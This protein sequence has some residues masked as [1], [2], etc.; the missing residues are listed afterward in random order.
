[1][2]EDLSWLQKV[3]NLEELIIEK[4]EWKEFVNGLFP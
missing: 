3:L 4:A 2:E 1:M